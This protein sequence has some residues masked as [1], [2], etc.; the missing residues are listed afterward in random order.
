[1]DLSNINDM[2]ES[3]TYVF[4]ELS[5]V[6]GA[7]CMFKMG[8]RC[9]FGKS[10]YSYTDSG[11]LKDVSYVTYMGYINS[12]RD[13]IAALT[14]DMAQ[15]P[16]R[17]DS[18]QTIVYLRT[19]IREHNDF[20]TIVNDRYNDV[21]YLIDDTIIEMAKEHYSEYSIRSIEYQ[22]GDQDFFEGS[23]EN[24]KKANKN[25]YARKQYR[26]K[27][28]V[29]KEETK[30]NALI[31]AFQ[32]KKRKK[33]NYLFLLQNKEKDKKDHLKKLITV[34]E[35]FRRVVLYNKELKELKKQQ[36]K[37]RSALNSGRHGRVRSIDDI[38][39]ELKRQRQLDAINATRALQYLDFVEEFKH[40]ELDNKMNK[41][42]YIAEK[43][44]KRLM[45]ETSKSEDL[46]VTN[47]SDIKFEA[48]RF[49]EY[50]R[51]PGGFKRYMHN[52]WMVLCWE[53]TLIRNLSV[54]WM[55]GKTYHEV[56]TKTRDGE[57]INFD[58]RMEML[59]NN[60]DILPNRFVPGFE[61]GDPDAEN[62]IEDPR[63][64]A[65]KR[66]MHAVEKV[67]LLMSSLMS[68]T[69]ISHQ[70]HVFMLFVSSHMTHGLT[71]SIFDIVKR[72]INE[73]TGI[74]FQAGFIDNIKDK[75]NMIKDSTSASKMFKLISVAVALIMS[76]IFGFK[77]DKFDMD[78]YLSLARPKREGSLVECIIDD[79]LFFIDKGISFFRTRSV[80]GLFLDEIV[81]KKYDEEFAFLSG[82]YQNVEIDEMETACGISIQTYMVRLEQCVED[83]KKMASLIPRHSERRFLTE[84]LSKLIKMLDTTRKVVEGRHSRIKPFG[85]M[86][87]G[88]SGV[89]KTTF[90]SMLIKLIMLTNP[91]HFTGEKQSICTM[92]G[93]DQYQTELTNAHQVVVLDDLGQTNPAFA[94]SVPGTVVINILNNEPK[95]ALKADVDSK[96]KVWYNCNLV[97]VTTNVK[98]LHSVVYSAEPAA[99]LRRFEVVIETTVKDEYRMPGGISID[100]TKVDSLFTDVW[101]F[102]VYRHIA[103]NN[104]Q[105]I[106]ETYTYNGELLNK[107]SFHTLSNFMRDKSREHFRSQA[108]L[109]RQQS[110]V[111]ELTLCTHGCL[112]RMCT[113]CSDIV[114]ESGAIKNIALAYDMYNDI[115]SLKTECWIA[116]FDTILFIAFTYAMI[117]HHKVPWWIGH[118]SVTIFTIVMFTMVI[119]AWILART[120]RHFKVLDYVTKTKFD[121]VRG[122]FIA[123]P[124]AIYALTTMKKLNKVKDIVD[125]QG[126]VLQK[127]IDDEKPVENCWK[128]PPVPKQVSSYKLATMTVPQG[129]DIVR[130]KLAYVE[131]E[132]GKFSNIMP[133]MSNMWLLNW[134]SLKDNPESVKVYCQGEDAVGSNFTCKISP[135]NYRRIGKTDLA[136]V[137]LPK[138]GSQ[139]N[140]LHMLPFSLS[141]LREGKARLIFKQKDGET[142][143][144]STYA[145]LSKVRLD[146]EHNDED[147]G[148]CY[149]YLL[150]DDTF[151]GLC[152]SCLVS[153]GK[154]PMILGF[155]FGGH[156]NETRKGF[157][158]VITQEDVAN[159]ISYLYGSFNSPICETT[160]ATTPKLDFPEQG[161][162]QLGGV[163][164]KSPVNFLSEGTLR[165]YGDHSGH[166]TKYK[167]N[168][169]HTKIA[170]DVEDIC[171]APIKYG[172]PKN[173]GSYK[174]KFSELEKITNTKEVPW[175]ALEFAVEDFNTH[176]MNNL[177]NK[178]GL[179][180]KVHKISNE[181]NLAGLD[182][183]RGLDSINWSTSMGHPINK[184]KSKFVKES[185]IPVE[186]IARPLEID[187]K[188]W[189]EVELMEQAM[190]RGERVYPISK[191]HLKDEPKKLD[192]EKV[193]VFYGTQFT[194][195][196]LVRRYCLTLAKFYMDHPEIFE[197]TVGMNVYGP[198]WNDMAH[199]LTMESFKRLVA[200][201][202]FSYDSFMAAQMILCGGK[203]LRMI[204]YWSENF[205]GDDMKVLIGIF[206]ELANPM[207]DFFGTYIEVMGCNI[208]GHSLTI[209]LN[210]WVNKLYVR[211]VY[212]MVYNGFPPAK[213]RDIVTLYTNGDD[214]IASVKKGHN[215]F[216]HTAI[217]EAFASFGVKYTMPDKEQ[218][219]VPY[220]ALEDVDY[221]RR[222]FVYNVKKERY[223]AA[224]DKDSIYRMLQ[225][226]EPSTVI[227]D[228]ELIATNINTA[229]QEMYYHGS[230]DFGEFHECM[231]IIV[232]KNNL[233]ANFKD[234]R[235]KSYVECEMFDDYQFKNGSQLPVFKD[236][237][238][239]KQNGNL[240]AVKKEGSG[241]S[242]R[243]SKKRRLCTG[244]QGVNVMPH[245]NSLGLHSVWDSPRGKPL[246]RGAFPRKTGIYRNVR[247]PDIIDEFYWI[248]STAEGYGDVTNHVSTESKIDKHQT[249]NFRDGVSQWIS[250]IPNM[251]DRTRDIGM[252]NDVPLDKFFERPILIKTLLWDPASVTKFYDNFNP[253]TLFF[254]QTRVLNRISNYHL[255]RAKLKV[256]FIVNGNSFYYGKLMAD[257][258]IR[259]DHDTVSLTSTGI[260]L[261]PLISASQRLHIFLNPTESQGGILCLPMIT[262]FNQMR[263]PN[264]DWNLQ[265]EIN[266]R[267]M[268]KL[269]HANG[270]MNPVSISV[271]AWAEDVEMSIPTNINPVSL[272]LQCGCLDADVQSSTTNDSA[273]VAGFTSDDDIVFQA[274]EY[275]SGPISN[276]M[277]TIANVAG[278]LRVY[279][280]IAPYAKA[281][282]DIA[283]AS[284]GLAKLFGFSRPAQIENVTVS[285]RLFIGPMT[286]IDRGDACVKLSLEAKQE[287]TVDPRVVGIDGVDELQIT[288]IAGKESW[289]AQF[290]WLTSDRVNKLL[291]TTFVTPNM[292]A[293]QAPYYHSTAC[294]F[295]VQPFTYWQGT[296]IYRF[297]IT[298]SAYHRG[299]LL[300]AYAP[301][302]QVGVPSTQTQYTRI[303]DLTD[304]RDFT[305]EV[306]WSSHKSFLEV[307][308]LSTVA[309]W[310][311]SAMGA[312]GNFANGTLSV[313]VLNDLTTPSDAVNND[314]TINV[315][316][317]A[318][319]DLSV[320]VPNGRIN[321]YCYMNTVAPQSGQVE[322]QE[323]SP[324]TDAP[325]VDDVQE[326]VAKCI[327]LDHTYD[328]YFGEKITSLRQLLK[329][330]VLLHAESQTPSA[331]Q[332]VIFTDYDFPSYRGYDLGGRHTVAGGAKANI[333]N[334]TLLTYIA[335]AYVCY[336]G[337][338]RSK[339]VANCHLSTSGGRLGVY[340][341]NGA[342]TRAT[343][344]VT[345]NNATSA[346]AAEGSLQSGY[347]MDGGVITDYSIDPVLEVEFPYYNDVRFTFTRRL[348]NTS[349]SAYNKLMHDT[350][351][352]GITGTTPRIVVER[353]ISVAEDF[354][355][356][357]FQGAPPFQ[358]LNSIPIT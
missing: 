277:S 58:G 100:E 92:N 330:Y 272:T 125:F 245:N 308:N 341:N 187:E 98:H 243:I 202:F 200:G 22:S 78:K 326:C 258:S 171:G 12:I 28:K 182:G 351:I 180:H 45:K 139:K 169:V 201:D 60:W 159:A 69:T 269:K 174:P 131:F 16:I 267:E 290:P 27:Q 193:R 43:F 37:A 8:S 93:D 63:V 340:R 84:R 188:Y 61:S 19:L 57:R 228:D 344:I 268:S 114:P 256:K 11:E 332:Q 94:K 23:S 284:G 328:V 215:E 54:G 56:Y 82:N 212:F 270:S 223:G 358:I 286:N 132:N 312:P 260:T 79:A 50:Y 36:T 135:I 157:S 238:I 209:I 323:S 173:I 309:N 115:H 271:Y 6:F 232:D 87:D 145:N 134:H 67:Y 240:F 229:L 124:V 288:H 278:R 15:G 107:C 214:N 316:C 192:S 10:L 167:S 303:V 197:T 350:L 163:H 34:H 307:G 259:K 62:R 275:S 80:A 239:E 20:V 257:Y 313:Y 348:D 158:Q 64:I 236:A 287:V 320:A 103:Q 91:E 102:R 227:S 38:N 273:K 338:M 298:A 285:K 242:R 190:I 294:G 47:L 327:E 83:T 251:W 181:V 86:L 226:Y 282:Q 112:N 147:M 17:D 324:E 130:Q 70:L 68:C 46:P 355:L 13:T 184:P 206:S 108:A 9:D 4:K 7:P 211:I 51:G 30:V 237:L 75:W 235:I 318:A 3:T 276:M 306:G 166:L 217:Q 1:M 136:V 241:F 35:E 230:R 299:R 234:H 297:M 116:L 198:E 175:D 21:P 110:Q 357:L 162:F 42:N 207:M 225:V 218:E 265:G 176:V 280:A 106:E 343:S 117:Q 293:Y 85:V 90:K 289:F 32:E 137:Y 89:G 55:Y 66:M 95:A 195:L 346:Q 329:R 156:R 319:D 128:I 5:F 99:P 196:L 18:W 253:W 325:I 33:A 129:L 339:Y 222:R 333:V 244:Y 111:Q 77:T 121:W 152:M 254:S 213:F 149:D 199:K 109:L 41:M 191:A 310:S 347:M 205:D 40:L 120:E 255:L 353:Y 74:D 356:F 31:E 154:N 179:K 233:R 170:K 140:I 224:L 292:V 73:N 210:D 281:T 189:K 314:I 161:V 274:G 133:I 194:F 335:P 53:M 283:G 261:N 101:E 247:D 337:G 142:K 24:N 126:G 248:P 150:E 88:R 264:E 146:K 165:I 39:K 349:L 301:T 29:I 178:E 354:N 220:L 127:P 48:G 185:S 296:M 300:F 81:A 246:F 219:S 164:P 315:F 216:N 336:R 72:I 322:E 44:E 311:N 231:N 183:M 119:R 105:T 14:F 295:A 76:S 279:P 151:N 113:E 65:T 2:F 186:G 122:A 155:H 153:E 71:S 138:G 252:S 118:I 25:K 317:K 52:S 160:S 96:G 143:D 123:I 141:E 266:I 291:F 221:L 262:E 334:T 204:A 26:R 302:Q 203:G 148:I 250:S 249:L 321:R 345:P 304:E 305:I 97:V 168:F 172:P 342:T 352:A 331:Y 49:M 59:L 263:I 104:G 144:F 177:R 208:S